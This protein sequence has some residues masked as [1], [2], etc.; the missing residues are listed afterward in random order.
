MSQAEYLRIFCGLLGTAAIAFAATP[1]VR[2]LAIRVKA[3][4]IPK[5][6]RRMHKKPIPLLGGLALFTAFI[7]AYL[8]LFPIT[9]ENL[10][11]LLGALVI[12]AVGTLDDIRPLSPAIKALGQVVA[13]LFPIFGGMQIDYIG[14]FGGEYLGFHPW[15]SVLLTLVW[16]F[17]I[18]NAIN[19]VDGLDGLAVG[20]SAISAIAMLVISI[21]IGNPITAVTSALLAGACLGFIPY[22]INPA[23]I[24]MGD[25]GALFLGYVLACLSVQGMFKAYTVISLF[26]PLC[27]FA[28]PLFD[29][30]TSFLRRLLKGKNP[31]Q[32]DKQHLHHKLILKGLTQTQS[33]LVLYSAS[34]IIG[35]AA[36]V[37]AEGSLLVGF[38]LMLVA[39]A[40]SFAL[41]GIFS[42]VDKETSK[43]DA[44]QETPHE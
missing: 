42:R 33:V 20:L 10:F 8:I 28:V 16:M 41:T 31:F 5:D 32:G 1:F 25:A 39:I 12:V 11:F 34:A 17:A 22:N 23:K 7:A 13:C 19:L 18:I 21:M 9:S 24:F 37:I 4:D 26:V 14:W 43:A 29:T 38:V 36:V 15:I 40:V 44:T 35:L 27:I 30:V 6:E 3:L 2:R